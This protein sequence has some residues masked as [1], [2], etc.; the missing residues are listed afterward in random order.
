VFVV[1]EG[2][3]QTTVEG[4]VVRDLTAGDAFGEV[5]VLASGRRTASVVAKTPM[6]LIALFKRDIWE[7]EKHNPAFGEQLRALT[8]QGS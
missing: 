1:I 3:A 5:A 7:L 2:T 8:A 6:T 4:R